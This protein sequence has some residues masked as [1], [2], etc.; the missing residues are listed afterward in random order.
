MTFLGWGFMLVS[1]GAI[2]SLAVFCFAKIFKK[3]EIE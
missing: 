3:K 2:L 1:W